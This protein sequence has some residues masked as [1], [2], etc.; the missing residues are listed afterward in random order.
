[1]IGVPFL[2]VA[3]QFGLKYE[4]GVAYGILRDYPV[5]FLDGTGCHRIMI[6]TRFM[7]PSQKDTLMD[8]INAQDLK[9]LYNIRKLQIAKKVIHIVFRGVPDTLEKVP[10][11]VDWFFPLLEQ[12]GATK[13]TICPQCM[14][15]M[16]EDE[17]QWVLRDGAVAFRMHKH[18]A[19][20]LK[21]SIAAGSKSVAEEDRTLGKGIAGAALGAL[22]GAVLWFLLQLIN[23]FA[24]MA[25][26]VTG[27]LVLFLYNKLGGS[28]G[29]ARLPVL[30]LASAVGIAL[31][32][33]LAEIPTL[34]QLGAGWNVLGVFIHTMQTNYAFMSGIWGNLSMGLIFGGIGLYI[35]LK[36][37]A[38]KTDEYVVTDLS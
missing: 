10:S 28:K 27:W 3:Q 26:A 35:S 34:V 24:P 7:T 1:M 31:G 38:R 36:S 14:E 13:A 20:D 22:A 17:V 9:G 8:I 30:I 16:A 4:Q 15:L 33:V 19:V 11:F 6:T 32:V 29:F 23:F 5:T 21:Q 12:N 25:G 18:C 37:E 2:Q